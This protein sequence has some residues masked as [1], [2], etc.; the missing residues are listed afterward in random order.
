MNF[1]K[2][3]LQVIIIGSKAV[4]LIGTAGLVIQAK[5]ATVKKD[6]AKYDVDYSKAHRGTYKPTISQGS[7]IGN[8]IYKK[9]ID[10]P[11][12]LPIGSVKKLIKEAK[13]EENVDIVEVQD[14]KDKDTLD[15]LKE[16]IEVIKDTIFE[17]PKKRE[18]HILIKHH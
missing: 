6:V 4:I 10:E 8:V 3:L 12:S 15:S 17:V 13:L 1:I 7:H 16:R 14:E 5:V 9:V 11:V 18:S 2:A